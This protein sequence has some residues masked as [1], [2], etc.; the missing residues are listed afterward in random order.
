MADLF[1]SYARPDRS[2]AEALADEF[3]RAGYSVWWDSELLGSDHF[4]EVIQAELY[5]ARACLVIWTPHSVKS[6]FVLDEADYALKAGKLIATRV[7]ALPFD[8]LPF[9]LAASTRRW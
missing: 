9:G 5:A 3:G 6:R 7:E 4:R 2:V 1:I 8:E